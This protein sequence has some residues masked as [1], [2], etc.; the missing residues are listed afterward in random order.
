M[1]GYWAGHSIRSIFL[2]LNH[3]WA[4]FEVCFGSLSCWNMTF[5]FSTFY[6]F[7]LLSKFSSKMSTYC[8]AS[9][10]PSTSANTPTPFH[11]IHSHTIRFPAPNLTAGVVVLSESGSPFFFH[12]YWCPSDP[13]LLILVSSDQITLFQSSTVYFLYFSAMYSLCFLWAAVRR[14]FLALITALKSDFFR[15]F[16]TVWGWTGC[17]IRLLINWVAWTALSSCPEVILLAILLWS[18]GESL[19][20][21]PPFSFSLFPSIVLLILDTVALLRS[22]IDSI[23]LQNSLVEGD[24]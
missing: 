19:E 1:S 24:Q 20:D 22:V 23:A 12:T 9:I 11:P 21:L 8:F 3:F 17:E 5:F 7:L 10:L 18:A 14:G 6:F 4:R 2:S 16:L 13:N 15:E